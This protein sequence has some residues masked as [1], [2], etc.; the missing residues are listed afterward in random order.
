MSDLAGKVA[1]VTGASRGI[2]RAVAVALARAGA[3]VAVNYHERAEAA[4]EVHR[5]IEQAGRRAVT[6]QA[7]VS[8]SG[9]VRRMVSDAEQALGPID[10]LINNAG[11]ARPQKLEEISERDWDELIEVN[12]KSCFLVTQAV[13][14]GM[15]RRRW[16]R[17]INISSVAAQVGGVVGPHYAASKAGMIGLTH[18]Y[19]ALLAKEGVTANAI[20]PALIATDMVL[21]N[22]RARPELIPVGRFGEADEVA[23]ACV[24]LAGNGYITGQTLN[25]N[26]GWYLS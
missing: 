13:V 26:G 19:A 3:D 22:L 2:G 1:L 11:I 9:E 17:I 12:L 4:A 21:Q 5:D 8:R 6:V 15:R 20:A 24:M 10:I 16:G 23:D 14:A 7:D 18:S 25:I